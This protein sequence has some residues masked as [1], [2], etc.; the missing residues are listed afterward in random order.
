METHRLDALKSLQL[1]PRFYR[2]LYRLLLRVVY[3]NSIVISVLCALTVYLGFY[4]F[5][6]EY[7]FT[8]SPNGKMLAL[9]YTVS[10]P[11]P[12]LPVESHGNPAP[13][14]KTP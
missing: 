2:S 9:T 5:K 6:P 3:V 12:K 11:S 14:P 7:Y 13:T 4:G 1:R 8:T 10:T